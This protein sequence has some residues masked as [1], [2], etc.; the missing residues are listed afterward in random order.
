MTL[1]HPN[2]LNVTP[3]VSIRLRPVSREEHDAYPPPWPVQPGPGEVRIY[4]HR[5]SRAG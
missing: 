2:S 1:P 4:H 3:R 5:G